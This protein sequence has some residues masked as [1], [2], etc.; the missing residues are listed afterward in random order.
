MGGLGDFF[1]EYRKLADLCGF[2]SVTGCD[3]TAERCWEKS[4]PFFSSSEDSSNFRNDADSSSNFFTCPSR[5]SRF[6][7]RLAVL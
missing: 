2:L 1:E 3:L 6:C 4:S 7:I 5:V